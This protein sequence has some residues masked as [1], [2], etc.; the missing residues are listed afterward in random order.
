[1]DLNKGTTKSGYIERIISA[2][3]RLITHFEIYS[4][5]LIADGVFGLRFA[6]GSLQK[7]VRELDK[8]NTFYNKIHS[9]YVRL[10]KL[11][12]IAYKKTMSHKNHYD[13]KLDVLLK[14]PY[15]YFWSMKSLKSLEHH[16]DRD[17]RFFISFCVT[18]FNTPV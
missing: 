3:E 10:K 16:I 14:Q 5:Q 7:L 18:Y 2:L 11:T 15:H 9:T 1:M 13:L 4:D 8:S 12:E 6:E 17:G